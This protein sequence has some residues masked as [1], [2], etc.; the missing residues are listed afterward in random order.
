MSTLPEEFT[1]ASPWSDHLKLLRCPQC[2]GELV[3]APSRLSCAGCDATF[4]I[5]DGIL[6]VKEQTDNN[7][8]VAQEFYD[9]ALWPKFRFWEKVTWVC[10]G[11]ERQRATQVLRHLPRQPGLNLLD[12]AVGDGVYLPWMP[13][14]WQVVGI[15]LSWSQLQVCRA[16]A[17]GAP[18][19]LV[20][21]EAETLPFHDAQ[22]DAVLSIGAFNYFNDPEG[23]LREMIRVGRPGAPIVIS[24]EM[25]DLTERMLGHKLGLPALDRWIVSRLMHLGDSFTDMVE[26]FRNLDVRSIAGRV[27]PE[28]QYHEV[29]RGWVTCWWGESRADPPRQ[30][31]GRPQAS[32]AGHLTHAVSHFDIAQPLPTPGSHSAHRHRPGGGDRGRAR[33]R[34]YR[35]ELRAFVPDALRGQAA[36][37]W[38]SSA[39][40]SATSSPARSIRSWAIGS[41]PWTGSLRWPLR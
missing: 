17:A 39:Q 10:N 33:P 36:S 32:R 20:Q 16:R 35:L 30:K 3:P 38:W 19:R 8:R 2:A 13:A 15:D 1:V 4:P 7:N 26:R 21:G 34:R 23:A 40:G 31:V 18:V 9:S 29:W 6:V 24:D 14:D 22:F 11:G 25:P 41:A 37:T 5:R 28:V 27:L 12:V